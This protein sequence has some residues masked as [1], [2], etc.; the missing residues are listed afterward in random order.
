MNN[1]LINYLNQIREINL[2]N[3]EL[4]LRV[5]LSNCSFNKE[6]IFLNNFNINK[7]DIY[8]F[9]SAFKRRMK[10]EPVSKIFNNKEFWNLNFLVNQS[11]L[12][13][14]PESEF[15][16]QT[17]KKYFSNLKSNIKICDLGTGSGC[18][19][20]ILA[21]IYSKSK[22]SAIDISKEAL[23]IA[24]KNAKKHNV[25]NQIKFLNC[26][27][28]KLNDR[29]DIILS[30]P[31]YL[32]YNEYAKCK[33]NIK[34][35]E[36]KIALMGGYDGLRSYRE[37]SKFIHSYMHEKSFLFIEMGK[38]QVNAIKEIFFKKKLNAIST[39]KDYHQIDRVLVL[40]K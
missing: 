13:P 35:F 16:I 34:N 24:V 40:K 17:I 22:I 12:D 15:L 19:A 27:W 28:S 3:P 26:D 33:I 21:K 25:D 1:F 18:L 30:N 7:I 14:R 29:F 32:S 8:K 4:E 10:Q 9:K 20:I 31:P 23:K 11:V 36:P 6:E 37:I 2:P 5:L 39:I 38:L